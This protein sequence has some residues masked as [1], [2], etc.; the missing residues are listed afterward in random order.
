MVREK[1]RPERVA[2]RNS[3]QWV[4]PC[5]MAELH[6]VKSPIILQPGPRRCR[7]P[8][9]L[10]RI[11]TAWVLRSQRSELMRRYPHRQGLFSTARDSRGSTAR[12]LAVKT[13]PR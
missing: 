4:L 5:A 1:F 7:W 2:A 11:I 9:A 3:W 6:E 10:H 8:D 12:R 13:S